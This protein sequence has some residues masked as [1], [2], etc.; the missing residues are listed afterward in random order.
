MTHDGFIPDVGIVAAADDA[1]DD[2]VEGQHDPDESQGDRR[3]VMQLMPPQKKPRGRWPVADYDLDLDHADS[4]GSSS[5][6]ASHVLKDGPRDW[7][8][9]RRWCD[10]HYES[11]R[12]FQ[13]VPHVLGSERSRHEAYCLPRKLKENL[14]RGFYITEDFAGVNTAT[15]LFNNVILV[16]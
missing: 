4:G 6:G 1:H 3:D 10:M 5:G 7:R 16:S 15:L 14:N 13:V 8:E 9:V 11:L 12:L 2:E